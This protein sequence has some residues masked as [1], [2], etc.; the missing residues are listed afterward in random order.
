MLT[1]D[2]IG[3]LVNRYRAVL[4]KCR[5]MNVFGSLAL[6]AMLIAGGM[7]C[8]V[9]AQ[10]GVTDISQSQDWIEDTILKNHA[11][12]GSFNDKTFTIKNGAT[13]SFDT[14]LKDSV[15]WKYPKYT[16]STGVVT[17]LANNGS[18]VTI[19]GEATQEGKFPVITITNKNN[20]E[21][22]SGDMGSE[23]G[24]NYA[25][26]SYGEQS[27]LSFNNV[28]LNLDHVA[29][30][31]YAAEKGSIYI[32][33]EFVNITADHF[34]ELQH[35]AI[36]AQDGS[37]IDIKSKSVKLHV[38]GISTEK[39]DPYTVFSSGIHTTYGGNIKIDAEDSLSVIVETKNEATD[40][41]QNYGVYALGQYGTEGSIKLSGKNFELKVSGAKRNNNIGLL[42][43]ALGE[44]SSLSAEF[45]NISI[46][47]AGEGITS[48]TMSGQA[49]NFESKISVTAADKLEI[50]APNGIVANTRWGKNTIATAANS[51]SIN[52][53]DF[54]ILNWSDFTKNNTASTNI[55]VT[56]N[57]ITL[58]SQNYGVYSDVRNQNGNT[59][60]IDVQGDTELT[61]NAPL[62]AYSFSGDGSKTGEGTINLN[63]NG[64][65]RTDLTG[66]IVARHK[67]QTNV[68]LNTG[69]SAWR[70][71]A[72]D[73]RAKNAADESGEINVTARNGATW[74]VS[75]V[76]AIAGTD[77]RVD[78]DSKSY[79]T[80]WNS[81]DSSNIDFRQGNN[82]YQA[83]D[84]GT[85]TGRGTT[86]WLATDVNGKRGEGKSTDQAIIHSG[87]GAHKIHVDSNGREP[88]AE[89]QKDYLVLHLEE[90]GTA[91]TQIENPAT[92]KTDG[93]EGK[94]LSFTL[95]NKGQVV[96]VGN[97]LYRLATRDNQNPGEGGTEWYLKRV[98]KLPDP[99]DPVTPPSGDD[100]PPLSPS[101]EAEAALSGLAGHYAL[102]WGLQTDLR[103]RLG[104]I[105][106]GTQEGLWVRGFADKARLDGLRGTGFSIFTAVP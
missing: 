70:G 44:S 52:S 88:W 11:L 94:A 33:N 74:H 76:T 10:E 91:S 32:D 19:N 71:F 105:R 66:A 104:E 36:V 75:P 34:D 21:Y 7:V 73:Y 43:G 27:H 61:I 48:E 81:L 65:G 12:V 100:N 30:G 82:T 84:I 62:V 106:Y 80:T 14:Q 69:D 5:L 83:V 50:D 39:N 15:Q 23:V 25:V 1:K 90:N 93:T 101:G 38:N 42:A 67:S 77:Y 57:N 58:L 87:S 16:F 8:P 41:A 51:L 17:I 97:Y 20:N 59:S 60:L 6:V 22:W 49:D 92:G 9:S 68:G 45:K 55:A 89:K 37:T 64:C 31:I 96:D 53:D 63:T 18:S 26:A 28:N 102:W 72:Q 4:K 29:E 79:L 3:K 24:S 54:V 86:F 85:L 13:L 56:G 46:Q 2:A 78:G 95:T 103:K 47:S 40:R 99:T 35:H 98:E